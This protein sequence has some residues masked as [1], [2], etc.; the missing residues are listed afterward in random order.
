MLF[1]VGK[2][3]VSKPVGFT[4]LLLLINDQLTPFVEPSPP[5]LQLTTLNGTQIPPGG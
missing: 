4:I 3:V 5:Q 1:H 2:V